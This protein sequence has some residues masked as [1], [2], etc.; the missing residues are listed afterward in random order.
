M[1]AGQARAFANTLAERTGL[2]GRGVSA[3]LALLDEGCTIPFIARY[4]KDRTGG[5]SDEDLRRLDDEL[6]D[7]RALEDRRATV[8]KTLT[9]AGLMTPER[10]RTLDAITD[11]RALEDFYRPFKPSRK[12]KASKAREA[13]LE[14]L[15]D[16]LVDPAE[17]RAPSELAAPFVNA[18][19]GIKS[20]DDALTGAADILVE[21]LTV[22]PELRASLRERR[23]RG[24]LEIKA[25]R[26]KKAEVAS[27]PYRDLPGRSIPVASVRDHQVLAID[28]GEREG[29][30][31]VK[32]SDHPSELRRLEAALVPRERRRSNPFLRE[33]C[34]RALKERAGPAVEGDIRREL[35]E[36]ARAGAVAGFRVNLRQLLMRPPLA[37]KIILGVD[38][39]FRAGCKC[40]VI[41]RD[42]EYL[43]AATIHPHSGQGGRTSAERE[44]EGLIRERAVEVIAVGNGTASRETMAF[45]RPLLKRLSGELGRSIPAVIVNEAG[46]SVY[47][48]SKEAA[49][50]HPELD[51]MVRGALSIARRLMDPLAELVKI[52]PKSLGVGQYQHDLDEKRLDQALGG[53][54]EQVVN[55][56]GVDLNRASGAL[57][58]RVSGIGPKL[59]R[60]IVKHREKRGA[61]RNREAL[62][63]VS[64]LGPKTYEQCAGFLRIP[65]GSEPLDRT[66]V[67]PESYPVARRI[68]KALGV[69]VE[70]LAGHES[71][72]ATLRPEDF[73]EDAV[74][75]AAVADILDELGEH[76]LEA[77]SDHYPLLVSF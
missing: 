5:L 11:R 40:A 53:V 22:D 10:A 73:A 62:T 55:E 33:V 30:L 39:G 13:G 50:E 75:P 24:R 41:G 34:A 4:R 36:R 56:V 72:L 47:S 48:A 57:L 25:G 12:T 68:A 6:G 2:P 15:A 17:A 52:D 69:A 64:G 7:L 31:S 20:R 1:S 45:L 28:R 14:P 49:A 74:G 66:A 21:R 65:D 29:L 58:T 19:L 44:L 3:A 61:F 37:R 42:G 23:R 38:P 76:R 77:C 70:D 51:V 71:R 16:Q 32:I 9:E 54:V 18:R 43:Q 67:H 63:E 59:A 26:G 27:S 60:T 35:T 46:A 8:R